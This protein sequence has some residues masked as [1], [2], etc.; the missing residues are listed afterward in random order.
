[1]SASEFRAVARRLAAYGAITRMTGSDHIVVFD[2]TGLTLDDGDEYLHLPLDGTTLDEVPPAWRSD[3]AAD[4]RATRWI[5][6]YLEDTFQTLVIRRHYIDDLVRDPFSPVFLDHL[7]DRFPNVDL[8]EIQAYLAE[9]RQWLAG[10]PR[11]TAT[12]PTAETFTIEVGALALTGD[13]WPASTGDGTHAPI[14]MLHGGGQTRHSWNRAA[15]GLA[16]LGH[17]VYTMDL[18]GHGDSAWPED[19]DYAV[20]AFTEDLLGTLDSLQIKP[21]IVGASLGGITGLNTVGR[22]LD[23]AAGLVLVDIVVDVEPEGIGRIKE[24]MGA[25]IDGFDTL[26]DVADAIAAYNPS[27]KRTRNLGGL[28]KNVRQRAD[29]RW[30]WHWDPRF[31]QGGDETRITDVEVLSEASRAVTVPTLLV[32][33]GQSDVVSQEGIDSMLTLIPHAEVADVSEAGHMVA[34]DDNQVF[35]SAIVEFLGRHGL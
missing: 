16:A 3:D 17:D 18:R 8:P 1:M 35:A 23:V 33:G 6:D 15:A 28:T 9:I 31:L 4:R 32:R 26:D 25:H 11:A 21:V 30:Y 22:H 2:D 13:R 20:D 27:R 7:A 10:R 29:G 19:A 5:E 24:F 12:A 14:L 34:G